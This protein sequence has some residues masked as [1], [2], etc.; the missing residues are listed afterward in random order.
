MTG[1]VQVGAGHGLV[2]AYEDGPTSPVGGG[3]GEWAWAVG[4]VDHS[5]GMGFLR[6]DHGKHN[7]GRV[8]SSCR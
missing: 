8:E 4:G 5:D 6:L 7:A 1:V 3:R 2:D